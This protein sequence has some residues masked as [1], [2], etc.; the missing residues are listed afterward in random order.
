[1]LPDRVSNPGP[2]TY[3]SGALPIALLNMKYHDYIPKGI[4][5]TERT[6]ICIKKHQRGNNLKS[7]KVRGL[8]SSCP[9]LHNCEVSSKYSKRYSS[10]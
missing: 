9:A 1:M 2:L 7:N 4:Q 10:Y 3:E 5:V 8:T 6:R